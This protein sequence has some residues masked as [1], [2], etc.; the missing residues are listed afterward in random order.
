MSGKT[1]YLST[2]VSTASLKTIEC[3]LIQRK[4]AG[5]QIKTIQKRIEAVKHISIYS[6]EF[7]NS[8][9]SNTDKKE[10][11]KILDS[12]QDSNQRPQGSCNNS[13]S[14]LVR[15][16]TRVFT[17]STRVHKSIKSGKKTNKYLYK[18]K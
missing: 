12:S 11:C 4:I 7:Y 13:H 16:K 6:S 9:L 5:G 2:C 15:V 18:N 3:K 14:N 17:N 10:I 8:K 1:C